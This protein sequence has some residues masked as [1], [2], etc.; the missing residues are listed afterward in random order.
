LRRPP[1]PS[2]RARSLAKFYKRSPDTPGDEEV[3]RYL[4]HLCQVRGLS[5]S[6]TNVTLHALRIFF[7]KTLR[8]EPVTFQ[9]PTPTMG[10]DIALRQAGVGHK[11]SSKI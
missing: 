11:E 4:L 9:L 2:L 3:Q 5:A 10:D 1:V 7:H 6:S 8:R